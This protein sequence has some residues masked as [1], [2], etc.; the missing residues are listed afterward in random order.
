MAHSLESRPPLLDHKLVEFAATLPIEEK[1]TRS[2]SLKHIFKEAVRPYVDDDILNRPKAGFTVP[3][4]AWFAGPL[5]TQFQ[6]SVLDQGYCLTYL[7][8]KTVRE[9]FAENQSGRRGHGERLWAIMQL[10][11]WLRRIHSQQTVYQPV[12]PPTTFLHSTI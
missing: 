10:E 3:L 12:T 8:E 11:L 6:D 7:T 9:L 1:V 4:D 2:G 5:A